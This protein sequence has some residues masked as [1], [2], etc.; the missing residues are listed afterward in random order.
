MRACPMKT[1]RPHP[2]SRTAY[3]SR[4]I[5]AFRHPSSYASRTVYFMPPMPG[6]LRLVLMSTSGI[7]TRTGRTGRRSKPRPPAPVFA[8]LKSKVR[9]L[10]RGRL[11]GMIHEYSQVV[12]G[13]G[14]SAPQGPRTHAD[15]LACVLDILR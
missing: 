7:T 1:H 11:G 10:R 13:G 8:C 12:Q 9:M 5:M 2:A 4:E 3:S 14:F 15:R 6:S